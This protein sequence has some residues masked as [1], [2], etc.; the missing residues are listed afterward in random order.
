[1]RGEDVVFYAP[2]D[3]NAS[4]MPVHRTASRRLHAGHHYAA[5]RYPWGG[6]ECEQRAGLGVPLCENPNA[7]AI[8]RAGIQTGSRSLDSAAVPRV[9]R[10]TRRTKT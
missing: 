4:S 2:K 3:A 9:T 10:R 5:A 7:S 8:L 6:P 1:M